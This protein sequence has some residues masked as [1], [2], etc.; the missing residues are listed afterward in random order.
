MTAAL[1]CI[2]PF[3]PFCDRPDVRIE[4]CASEPSPVYP[5]IFASALFDARDVCFASVHVFAQPTQRA[6]F[7]SVE[8]GRCTLAAMSASRAARAILEG[9]PAKI[10]CAAVA[11]VD[12]AAFE[13]EPAVPWDRVGSAVRALPPRAVLV[14]PTRHLDANPSLVRAAI[15][16]Y[17]EGA[18]RA[19]REPT[20]LSVVLATELGLPPAAA[21]LEALRAIRAWRLDPAVRIE[22]LTA[23]LD[24]ITQER[25]F[26]HSRPEWLLDE[27]F[28]RADWARRA[29]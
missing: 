15:E 18:V 26:A 21:E 8:R 13:G 3:D 22:G 23:V 1:Q 24:R 6:L 11:P 20:M 28:V 5:A 4:G 14:A 29:L 9:L 25:A 12:Y 19:V 16:A 7:D 10:V 17:W 27:R 2:P